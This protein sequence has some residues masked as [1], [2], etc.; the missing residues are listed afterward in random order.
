M[1][2]RSGVVCVRGCVIYSVVKVF[3]GVC[4]CVCVC[5]WGEQRTAGCLSLFP[6]FNLN[7]VYVHLCEADMVV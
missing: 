3:E 1:L 2:D 5:V 6:S 7:G 4:V